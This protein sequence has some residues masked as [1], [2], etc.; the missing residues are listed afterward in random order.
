[1]FG[2]KEKEIVG[3]RIISSPDGVIETDLKKCKHCGLVWQT[4]K[5][6][7]RERF[8]CNK[9]AG[10]C[11]SPACG[12]NCY[13]EEQRILDEAKLLNTEP[14]KVAKDKDLLEIFNKVYKGV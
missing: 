11:C 7:G 3:H 10:L 2:V 1:M 12:I 9:C 13:P 8:Y 5:G 14:M 6:S 4:V